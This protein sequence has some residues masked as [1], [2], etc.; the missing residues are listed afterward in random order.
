MKFRKFIILVQYSLASLFNG[1]LTFVGYLM[2]KPFLLKNSDG[3]IS[4]IAGRGIKRFM[5]F[6]SVLVR[7]GT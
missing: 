3:I 7:K 6:P 5:P 2:P 1:L 4:P